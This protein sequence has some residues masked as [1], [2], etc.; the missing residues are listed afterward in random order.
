MKDHGVKTSRPATQGRDKGR[1]PGSAQAPKGT[2]TLRQQGLE[3]AARESEEEWGEG[4]AKQ[5]TQAGSRPEAAGTGWQ[6]ARVAEGQG[7]RSESWREIQGQ[8]SDPAA[9]GLTSARSGA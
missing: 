5:R 4:Q 6:R 7:G 2:L 3:R 8:R 1:C 9:A